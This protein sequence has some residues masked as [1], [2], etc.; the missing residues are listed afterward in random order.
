[1]MKP[2][3]HLRPLKS[4]RYP[5]QNLRVPYSD[6]IVG[7]KYDMKDVIQPTYD[8]INEKYGINEKQD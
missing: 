7:G 5:I 3:G 2:S 6:F 8:E 4:R 1:M